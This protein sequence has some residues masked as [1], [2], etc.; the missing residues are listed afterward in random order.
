VS[1]SSGERPV[2]RAAWRW[3]AGAAALT[4]FPS[5][6]A[7][8][9]AS[10]TRDLTIVIEFS[11]PMASASVFGI[12]PLGTTPTVTSSQSWRGRTIW[13]GT[14][15]HDKIANDGSHDG[16]HT[17][18]IGGSDLAGNQLLKI[19]APDPMGP[20]HHN[21]DSTGTVRGDPGR[22]TVHAFKIGGP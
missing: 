20:D 8:E 11:E 18:S 4:F 16:L 7:L 14:I 21:R 22:D 5:D 3:N 13:S 10:R 19:T 12:T 9:P 15:S 2:Y 6:P 17:L 1:I